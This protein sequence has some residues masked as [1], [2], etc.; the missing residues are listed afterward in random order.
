MAELHLHGG[1]AVRAAVLRALGAIPDCRPAEAG[2]FTRRAFLNGRLDLTEAEGIADLIEAETEAQRVQALRQL[3]GALGGRSRRGA[4]RPS[5]SWPRRKPPSISPTRATWTTAASTPPSPAAPPNSRRTSEKPLRTGG[6]ASACARVFAWCWPGRR[7]PANRPAQCA[8][9]P[10]RGHRL[11][12]PRHHPRRHRGALRPR[13]PPRHAGR[14]RRPARDRRPGRSRG[15][16]P[17]PPPH[18][19]RRPR[20]AA[21]SHRRARAGPGGG[22]RQRYGFAPRRIWRRLPRDNSVR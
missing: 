3:E 16:R 22:G 12:H 18:R 7:M 11:R 15:R 17:H 10:R 4:T 8:G 1:T 2:A 19:N 9:R 20:V 6:A 14:Y 21:H 5:T 13:R